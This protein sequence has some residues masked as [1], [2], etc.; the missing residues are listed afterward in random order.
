MKPS[1]T[2]AP[3]VLF[4]W[5]KGT[6]AQPKSKFDAVKPI[7]INGSYW[8]HSENL[9]LAALA[10][11]RAEVQKRAFERILD[12]RNNPSLRAQ[13]KKS[14]HQLKQQ[15]KCLYKKHCVFVKPNLNFDCNDQSTTQ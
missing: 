2:D 7:V 12:I 4:D 8:F 14:Q 5:V 9:V 1:V 13:I 3:R 6:T 15:K 11:E 10:D